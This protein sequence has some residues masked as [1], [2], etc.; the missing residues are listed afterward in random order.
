MDID[1]RSAL[2]WKFYS[3]SPQT[4]LMLG[5]KLDPNDPFITV[6]QWQ[7]ECNKLADEIMRKQGF[8]I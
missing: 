3:A 8:D 2:R 7:A 4:A 6:A 5:T 1:E